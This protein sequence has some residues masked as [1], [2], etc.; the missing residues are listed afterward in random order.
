M[1]FIVYL[2]LG[3]CMVSEGRYGWELLGLTR[4]STY[5]VTGSGRDAEPPSPPKR[6]Y[7]NSF[8][9]R[10]TFEGLSEGIEYRLFL[11][12]LSKSSGVLEAAGV[13]TA[14]DDSAVLYD[15]AIG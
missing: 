4:I 15:S 9:T 6:R 8:P 1:K 11:R 2:E 5:E 13:L 3:T 10:N 14:G 12:L 7:S